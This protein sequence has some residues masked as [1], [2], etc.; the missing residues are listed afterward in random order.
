MEANRWQDTH[1][2]FGDSEVKDKIYNTRERINQKFSYNSAL[3]GHI[4]EDK[5]DDTLDRCRTN[6]DEL[7]E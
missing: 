4:L 1:E 6:I 7:E 5:K 2:V 3:S